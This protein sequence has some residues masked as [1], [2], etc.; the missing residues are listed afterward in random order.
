MN[1]ILF[2]R[3]RSYEMPSQPGDNIIFICRSPKQNL[4]GSSVN[5]M[6]MPAKQCG[7]GTSPQKPCN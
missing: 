5:L 2:I 7:L 4:L 6:R 1:C 3:Q